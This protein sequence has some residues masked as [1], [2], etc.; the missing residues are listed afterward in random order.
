MIPAGWEPVDRATTRIC[1]AIYP[2]IP[3]LLITIIILYGIAAVKLI[4]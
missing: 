2:H 4:M 1:E 3:K